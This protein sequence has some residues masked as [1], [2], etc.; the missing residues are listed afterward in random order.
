MFKRM[1]NFVTLPLDDPLLA[2][3]AQQVAD[4]ARQHRGNGHELRRVKLRQKGQTIVCSYGNPVQPEMRNA[5]VLALME[6][7]LIDDG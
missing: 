5:R 1:K 3:H 2:E 6:D 4:F 7:E